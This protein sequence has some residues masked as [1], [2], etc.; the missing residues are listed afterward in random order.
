MRLFLLGM[1]LSTA[2]SAGALRFDNS[3]I[4]PTRS[5]R[6]PLGAATAEPP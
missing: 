1:L 3:V 5:I 4:A 2:V 6:S